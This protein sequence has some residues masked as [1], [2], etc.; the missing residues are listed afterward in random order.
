MS[1]SNYR[2]GAAVA[3]SD[4]DRASLLRQTCPQSRLAGLRSTTSS[5]AHAGSIGRPFSSCWSAAGRGAVE[6]AEGG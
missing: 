4:M 6:S 3:V 1:L 2:V 5:T